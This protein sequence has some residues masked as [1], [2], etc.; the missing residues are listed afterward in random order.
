MI[1]NWTSVVSRIR[2]ALMRRGRSEQDADDLVQEAWVRLACYEQEQSVENPEA[3]LMQTALNLSV[4]AH[5]AATT[6]GEE[7]M[8]ED[9]VILDTS[10]GSEDVVLA[11][12]RMQRLSEGLGR[13]NERTRA[14]FLAHRVEGLTYQEIGRIQGITTSSVERHVAKALLL[15]TGWMEG[16][17]P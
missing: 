6:R 11:R 12:E 9:V 8:F 3:F 13:L 4:D 2:R 1:D 15:I 17:Y 16:W 5:R 7:V 10:P 14:I